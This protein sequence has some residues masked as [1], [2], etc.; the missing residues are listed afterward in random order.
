MANKILENERN[1]NNP[2]VYKGYKARIEYNEELN[3]LYGSVSGIDRTF[4]FGGSSLMELN[5]IFH[6][7][8]DG[9]LAE[10][11]K[12]GIEP[13]KQYTGRIC[14]DISPEWHYNIETICDKYGMSID[15]FVKAALMPTFVLFRDDIFCDETELKE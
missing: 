5:E 2:F 7:M 8:I 4:V 11:E 10:C 9:Y 14:V 15:D 12:E 1:N 3:C 13:C 6:S